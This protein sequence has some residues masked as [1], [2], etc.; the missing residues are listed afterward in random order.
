MTTALPI[1]C[2][3]DAAAHRDRTEWIAALN[4]RSLRAHRRDHMSLVLT[5]D[6]RAAADIE[7]LVAQERRCC[8]FLSFQV[9]PSIDVVQLTVTAPQEAT[10]AL[11]EIFA[12]FLS[13]AVDAA[14]GSGGRHDR[15]FAR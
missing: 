10:S 5:Y 6:A 8:A 4:Q 9:A 2:T 1:A 12:P 14:P 11:A 3:L 15:P 13:G 7:Q